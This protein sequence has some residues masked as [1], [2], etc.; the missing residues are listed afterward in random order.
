MISRGAFSRENP[1][2][3]NLL[4]AKVCCEW[5]LMQFNG[6]F[7]SFTKFV[8]VAFNLSLWEL[9]N[10]GE[11]EFCDAKKLRTDWKEWSLMEVLMEWLQ[12]FNNDYML[13]MIWV[14]QWNKSQLWVKK[15]CSHTWMCCIILLLFNSIE[16]RERGKQANKWMLD[17]KWLG[18]A[19]ELLDYS[20]L[21]IHA[22][23]NHSFMVPKFNLWFKLLRILMKTRFVWATAS[24][25]HFVW[26]ENDE[27]S[28][29]VLVW[30][31]FDWIRH[32]KTM[33]SNR[34]NCF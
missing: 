3:A 26:G 28:F 30:W 7:K 14:K 6:S 27:S 8:S 22:N 12:F 16:K 24:A 4:L 18:Q 19:L 9:E 25:I 5:K 13:W 10:W 11:F 33:E 32:L 15:S 29:Y 21:I 2:E 23:V 20:Y 17:R 34:K 1:Q 31:F